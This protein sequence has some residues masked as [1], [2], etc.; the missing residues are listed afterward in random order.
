MLQSTY[1]NDQGRPFEDFHQ[2]FKDKRIILGAGLKVF[3]QY[4]L[5]VAN[6]F[7]G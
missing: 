5:R 1:G 6:R 3:F 4:E 7:Q 2:L